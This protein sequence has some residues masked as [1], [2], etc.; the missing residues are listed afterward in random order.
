MELI[1]YNKHYFE[2]ANYNDKDIAS[3]Q[4]PR[5]YHMYTSLMSVQPEDSSGLME[6]LEDST[7][8]QLNSI[9]QQVNKLYS[10]LSIEKTV[11]T[12]VPIKHLHDELLLHVEYLIMIVR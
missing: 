12:D 4:I 10:M 1:K 7:K 3:K 2:L 6:L 5:L 9:A 11:N 8:Q